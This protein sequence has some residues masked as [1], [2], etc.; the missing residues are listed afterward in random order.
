MYCVD[1]SWDWSTCECTV[2]CD[3]DASL[4]A[5]DDPAPDLEDAIDIPDEPDDLDAEDVEDEG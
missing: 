2:W 3:A 5:P 1:G 4:D